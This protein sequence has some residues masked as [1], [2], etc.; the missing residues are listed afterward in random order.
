MTTEDA[1]PEAFTD[2]LVAE[3]VPVERPAG[4]PQMRPFRTLRVRDRTRLLGFFDRATGGVVSG[5]EGKIDATEMLDAMLDAVEFLAVDKD[6]MTAW[7]DSPDGDISGGVNLFRWYVEH[8][9]VG[10]HYAS[11]SF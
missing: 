5:G 8:F 4:A 2:K 7:L 11:L 6:Q 9:K 10:D 3:A 1:E